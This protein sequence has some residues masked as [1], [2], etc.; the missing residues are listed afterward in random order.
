MARRLKDKGKKYTSDDWL[1]YGGIPHKHKKEP[2]VVGPVAPPREL[3]E[4]KTW[5]M[6]LASVRKRRRPATDASAFM[7]AY[8]NL[9]KKDPSVKKVSS[10]DTLV[11]CEWLVRG[12][13]S[14]RNPHMRTNPA[15]WAYDERHETADEAR[16]P[17]VKQR[18]ADAARRAAEERTS[19]LREP[20]ADPVVVDETRM[21]YEVMIRGPGIE[22]TQNITQETRNEILRI[23]YR[24]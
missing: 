15:G 9:S 3:G 7:D 19:L 23:L 22:L 8:H 12:Y 20:D 5:G 13:V 21:D 14:F 6:L 10:T 17:V 18:L 4:S 11:L 2:I 1:S 24:D 16:P